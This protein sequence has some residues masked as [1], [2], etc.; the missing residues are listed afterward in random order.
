M[1]FDPTGTQ[2]LQD[3]QI[4]YAGSLNAI[5]AVRD[6]REAIN[7]L[8]DWVVNGSTSNFIVHDNAF[9]NFEGT[10]GSL[11]YAKN[12]WSLSG[13]K[14][15]LGVSQALGSM[16]TVQYSGANH[17]YIDVY[18]TATSGNFFVSGAGKNVLT[19]GI[20][21]NAWR[22]Y[23]N[24]YATL[25]Q[26]KKAVWEQFYSGT[27]NFFTPSASILQFTTIG[28][29][30]SSNSGDRGKCV[31]RGLNFV[32]STTT[33]G[34]TAVSYNLNDAVAF[35][36]FSELGSRAQNDAITMAVFGPSGTTLHAHAIDIN[37]DSVANGT[38]HSYTGSSYIFHMKFPNTA[39]PSGM[40]WGVMTFP[41]GNIL[42][43]ATQ[44]NEATTLDFYEPGSFV[45]N[46]AAP[47]I[48]TS[49]CYMILGGGAIPNA[50]ATHALWA[51]GSDNALGSPAVY[52]QSF[53]V[54][55]DSGANWTTCTSGVLTSIAVPGSAAQIRW[56]I[57]RNAGGAGSVV[58][59]TAYAGW[60]YR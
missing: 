35:E 24:Q 48:D 37:D 16:V 3:G 7:R 44:I 11:L 34:S 49:G 52:S 25:N 51:L 5:L 12:M 54:S 39:S 4:L 2:F 29:I 60:F 42:T 55:S 1:A 26:N 45:I 59:A 9:N 6:S 14:Y 32:K 28:S 33:A 21:S 20:G 13:N 57:N 40:I 47:P 36:A 23:C 30:Y 46:A 50:N 8:S 19:F 31:Y 58:T 53:Q 15:P 56:N 10:A 43:R 18:A 27:A 17:Y 38:I 41:S 22:I